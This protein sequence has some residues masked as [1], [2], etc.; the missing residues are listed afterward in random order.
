MKTNSNS[1]Q[2]KR[3]G[4]ARPDRKHAWPCGS[5]AAGSSPSMT[6]EIIGPARGTLRRADPCQFDFFPNEIPSKTGKGQ[7]YKKYGEVLQKDKKYTLEHYK[8]TH[9]LQNY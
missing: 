2:A 6:R 9:A 7:K 3:V 1:E 4:P 5:R 8:C